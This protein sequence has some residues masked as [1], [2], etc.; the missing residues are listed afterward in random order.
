MTT[1]IDWQR[2]LDRSI[3]TGDDLPAGH[4]VA[5]GHRAVRRR[6]A[7][8]VVAGLGA[9]AV[10]AGVAWAAGQ[11]GTTSSSEAP[12]ATDPTATST[13]TSAPTP[14]VEAKD[15][16]LPWRNSDPPARTGRTGLQIRPGA[17]VHE[18]RDDLFPGK[19]TESV[20]LDL[21]YRG[22]RWWMVLE[23]DD[24]GGGFGSTRPEDGLFDSFDDFVRAEISGGGMTSEP[25]LDDGESFGGLVK[26]AGGRVEPLPGVVVV[27]EVQDPV[28]SA[29]DS[30]GLV[31]GSRGETTWMLITLSPSGSSASYDKESAS[32]WGTFDQW[33]ADQVALAEGGQGPRPVRLGE[34]GTV[35]A[36]LPG[37]DVLDQHADP[38]L[39]SY[40]TAAEGAT[41]AVALVDWQGRRWFVL[42]VRVQ[43]RD[44]VTT[45][46]VDKTGGADTLDEFVAFMADKADEGGMR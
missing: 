32:G 28:S 7:V 43:G 27:R 5:A 19:G 22:E 6:R 1:D 4:Y 40:G 39:Q 26:W 9:A 46:A 15:V 11:A 45:V 21:S 8:A 25:A 31:L 41:S 38:D 16:T 12:I 36:A 13:P 10:V 24:G 3:G 14:V 44:S 33:L 2:E 20:A 34:D 42:V 35:S 23:W 17:V 18:R 29:D 30:L 37:V